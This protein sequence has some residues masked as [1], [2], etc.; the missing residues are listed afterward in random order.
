ME[1]RDTV[2]EMRRAAHL[3]NTQKNM[4]HAVAYS[5]ETLYCLLLQ[6]TLAGTGF[7]STR[8]REY[9]MRKNFVIA[10]KIMLRL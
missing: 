4:D 6:Q 1:E 8:T 7:V 5:F 2:E 3:P 9:V 10:G